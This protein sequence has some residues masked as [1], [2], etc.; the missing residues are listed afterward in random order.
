MAFYEL[1]KAV[2]KSALNLWGHLFI[3][4]EDRYLDDL[5]LVVQTPGFLELK[6]AVIWDS[7]SHHFE[8]GRFYALIFVIKES[9]F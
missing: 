1:K 8:V 4:E 7:K 3:H 6:N 5:S 2:L 9:Q